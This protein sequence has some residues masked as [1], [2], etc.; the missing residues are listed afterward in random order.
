MKIDKNVPI[1]K[2]TTRQYKYPYE[3]MEVGDSFFIASKKQFTASI[4]SY[5]KKMLQKGVV[6]KFITRLEG[7]GQRCWR[8][9]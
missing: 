7:K 5:E 3:H 8:V 4:R 6:V 9:E 2:A 1:P